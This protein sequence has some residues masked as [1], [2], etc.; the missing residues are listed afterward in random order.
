[1]GG[2]LEDSALGVGE[3]VGPQDNNATRDFGESS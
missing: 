2:E 3:G 1:M